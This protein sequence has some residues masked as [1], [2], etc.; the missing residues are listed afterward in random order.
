MSDDALRVTI[1]GPDPLVA[2]LD[3]AD[4]PPTPPARDIDVQATPFREADR[5]AGVARYSVS[6]DGWVFAVS[7]EPA[8]L[9][10]L[11]ERATGA[12]ARGGA[13]V[14]QV[15]RAQIPGRVVRVWVAVGDHVGQ[16]QRLLAVEAM[17]MENEVRA[18][19]AGTVESIHVA[20]GQTVDLGV[21]LVRIS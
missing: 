18:L 14:G 7:V 20:V 11:R 4:L 6:H 10:R 13:H 3:P 12:A 9:A 2:E 16:G 1:E 17:K 15:I 5:S 21:D 8:R 19:R